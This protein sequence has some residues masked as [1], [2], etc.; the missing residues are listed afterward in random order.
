MPVVIAWLGTLV[1]STI[2]Q[3]ALSAL[4]GV[5]VGLV[6]MKVAIEPGEALIRS[7][8]AQSGPMLAYIGWFGVDQA[9]TIIV[10][11]WI[12]RVAVGSA[13][14]YFVRRTK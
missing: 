4:V 9:V 13:R 10:S 1:A 12:G 3:W 5:G 8:F 11:A 6:T 14:A 2:G 7:Y